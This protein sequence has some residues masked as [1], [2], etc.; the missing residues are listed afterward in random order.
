M[1]AASS[2]PTTK[3]SAAPIQGPLSQPQSITIP[4]IRGPS[5]DPTSIPEYTSPYTDPTERLGVTLRTIISR[6]G[7]DAPEKKPAMVMVNMARKAGTTPEASNINMR[8]DNSSD[9]STTSSVR[10]VALTRKP[11]ANIPTI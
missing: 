11:P 8:A 6:D 7:A 3:A 9:A 10:G 2:A 4:N 5:A 1:R